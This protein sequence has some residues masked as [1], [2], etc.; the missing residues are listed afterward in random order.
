M[1]KVPRPGRVK[2]RL[3]R[4]IGIV[5][6]AWWFRHQV[7]C[8]L[9]RLSDPR[10]DTI[11]AVSPDIEGLNSRAWPNRFFRLS[12]GR[13]DL[14]SRMASVFR[15]LP[16]GPAVVIGAD[17]PGVT[18]HH[19]A[20][21]FR[22]LGRN[23]CVVGPARDG[24]YWLIGFRHG[25]RLP[26]KAFTSVRWSGRHALNDTLATLEGLSI[27]DTDILSDVDCG[28]DLKANNS[29]DGHHRP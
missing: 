14:G 27:A 4:D 20:G 19:I 22:L 12:Q 3:G 25:N 18:Q 28:S 26:R 9:R 17:I 11:L 16:P 8:L 15:R 23:D 21:A 13:G 6:S 10:W 5:T 1:V 2:T 29:G 24:G 7:K